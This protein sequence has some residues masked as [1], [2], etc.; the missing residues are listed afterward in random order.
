MIPLSE[1]TPRDFS[2][3]EKK[4]KTTLLSN[5]NAAYPAADI[6]ATTTVTSA[7]AGPNTQV[8]IQLST[9]DSA[10]EFPEKPGPILVSTSKKTSL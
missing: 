1:L 3:A 4:S 10:L 5:N 8:R 2:T 7:P 9:R 6:M